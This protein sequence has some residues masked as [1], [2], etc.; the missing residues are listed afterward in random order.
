MFKMK[1]IYVYGRLSMGL[2]SLD[3]QPLISIFYCL[4]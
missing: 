3:I 2:V 1:M 4:L